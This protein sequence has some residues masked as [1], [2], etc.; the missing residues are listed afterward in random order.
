[1]W[2]DNAQYEGLILGTV[3]GVSFDD[4]TLGPSFSGR[5]DEVWI[6]PTPITDVFAGWDRFCPLTFPYQ[7]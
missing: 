4:I 7:P 2:S 5:I 1:V 3:S 6:S